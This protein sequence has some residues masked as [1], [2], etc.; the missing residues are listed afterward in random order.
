MKRR[1]AFA[2][3]ILVLFSLTSLSCSAVQE[4]GKAM[5]N[6]QRCQFKLDGVSDFSLAG[7]PISG[8]SSFSAADALKLLPAF[9]TK[10]FPASFNVNVA[11][12]NPNDGSGGSPQ[13]S[14]TLT[15]LAWTLLIDSTVT[16]AGDIPNPVVIPGTGQ[17]VVIP[18]RMNLDLYQFF[19]NRGYQSLLNLALALGGSNRS[20][21]RIALRAK[22]TIRTD[23]GNITYPGEI[24][25]I[26]REFRGK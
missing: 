10:Q 13:A 15:S 24:T 7:I 20:A 2:F 26:D 19:Q 18:L 5:M 11:A 23:F 3:V 17:Q 22:P 4:F 16:I 21:S 1:V 12:L 8:K 6:L 14:A 25:I 9:Q